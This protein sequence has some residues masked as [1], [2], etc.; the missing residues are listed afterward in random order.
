[1][2]TIAP[3]VD[4]ALR[5][6]FERRSSWDD[7]YDEEDGVDSRFHSN[8]AVANANANASGGGSQSKSTSHSQLQQQSNQP[9]SAIA[10]PLPLLVPILDADGKVVSVRAA[11]HSESSPRAA[12]AAAQVRV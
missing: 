6:V 12:S 2:L 7:G 8:T 3:P 10:L 1:M 4:A 9:S 11:P 5:R